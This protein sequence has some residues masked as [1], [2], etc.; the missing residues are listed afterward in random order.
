MLELPV[1]QHMQV[2]AYHLH[3][4]NLEQ[5]SINPWFDLHLHRVN[6]LLM[7]QNVLVLM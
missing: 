5:L 6:Q 2:F 4:I 1:L 3:S 7:L